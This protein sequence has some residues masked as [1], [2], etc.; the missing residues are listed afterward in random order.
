MPSD[1][2][3]HP[4]VC[5]EGLYTPARRPG[6]RRFE[7]GHCS[8]VGPLSRSRQTSAPSPPQLQVNARGKSYLSFVRAPKRVR[9]AGRT[10]ARHSRRVG[11]LVRTRVGEFLQKFPTPARDL[12]QVSAPTLGLDMSE[13]SRSGGCSSS[14]SGGGSGDVSPYSPFMSI[15]QLRMELGRLQVDTSG[16]SEKGTLVELLRTHRSGGRGGEGAGGH[17]GAP[18]INQLLFP[19]PG[20]WESS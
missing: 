20:I 8:L 2:T 10:C 15:R 14:S 16:V 12:S 3:K 5:H 17:A 11:R 7:L 13:P 1:A 4:Q 19:A 6:A 9:C 18:A